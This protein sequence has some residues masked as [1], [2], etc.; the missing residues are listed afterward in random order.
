MTNLQYLDGPAFSELQSHDRCGW[1]DLGAFCLGAPSLRGQ[2]RRTYKAQTLIFKVQIMISINIEKTVINRAGWY[3]LYH[4]LVLSVCQSVCMYVCMPVCLYVWG[5]FP[6][7]TKTNGPIFKIQTPI[8]RVQ[9]R[10]VS[11]AF[12]FWNLLPVSPGK[13]KMTFENRFL[14]YNLSIYGRIFEIRFDTSDDWKLLSLKIYFRFG[15]EK[16]FCSYPEN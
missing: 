9:C 11:T 1:E 5:L 15:R 13:L 12:R 3:H 10:I 16:A 8:I 6:H 7:S 14:A 2:R 4:N